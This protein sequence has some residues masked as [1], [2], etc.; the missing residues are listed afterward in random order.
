MNSCSLDEAGVFI[1]EVGKAVVVEG[2][3]DLLDDGT[4]DL[5]ASVEGVGLFGEERRWASAICA[6]VELARSGRIGRMG[7][8]NGTP[9][10]LRL[11]VRAL[12]TSSRYP[13]LPCPMVERTDWALALHCCSS[14]AR[15]L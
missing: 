4:V 10:E 6:A 13:R 15:L 2:G 1:D 9:G 5:V 8:T 3:V 14:W 12:L 11:H 7:Q